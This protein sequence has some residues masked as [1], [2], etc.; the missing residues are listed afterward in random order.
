MP[1]FPVLTGTTGR[2]SPSSSISVFWL[3]RLF[4][5][6]V[7][8]RATSCVSLYVAGRGGRGEGGGERGEGRGEVERGE[9][10]GERG[11]REKGRGEVE[12]GEGRGGRV[13]E[14]LGIGLGTNSPCTC[15]FRNACVHS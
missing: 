2:R 6:V 10:R 3:R 5:A 15:L 14:G 8:C 4:R 1:C 13:M 12:R 11:E 9:G 7:F